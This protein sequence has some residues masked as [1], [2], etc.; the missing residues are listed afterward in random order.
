MSCLS[1]SIHRFVVSSK[2]KAIGFLGD[3]RPGLFKSVGLTA[4]RFK[5]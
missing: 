1:K 2:A 4:E 5:P 3:Q